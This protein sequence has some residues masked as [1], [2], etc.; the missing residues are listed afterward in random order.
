[1]IDF[2]DA[3]VVAIDF[4]SHSYITFKLMKEHNR[5]EDTNSKND[6]KSKKIETTNLILVELVEG[7]L[8]LI[9]IFILGRIT[10]GK[11]IIAH[12]KLEIE[13]QKSWTVFMNGNSR[14]FFNSLF[15]NASFILTL[16][17]SKILQV[18]K[19]EKN[20]KVEK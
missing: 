4:M 12:L 1:M 3:Q 16:F 17:I 8:P 6:I 14:C 5:V 18:T 19:N 15:L 20:N 13:T 7:I 9:F 2:T 11:S 10:F